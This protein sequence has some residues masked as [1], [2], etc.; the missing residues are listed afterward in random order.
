VKEA[1]TNKLPAIKY[2]TVKPYCS[3]PILKVAM[4]GESP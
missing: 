4:Y 1:I 3:P 2:K